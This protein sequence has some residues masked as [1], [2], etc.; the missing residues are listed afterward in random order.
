MIKQL[1]YRNPGKYTI[2][3][4]SGIKNSRS[5][6]MWIVRKTPDGKC[7]W[8]NE[9]AVKNKSAKYCD[10]ECGDSAM[11]YCYPQARHSKGFMLIKQEFKCATCVKDFSE[12]I[13][14][15]IDRMK[16]RSPTQIAD[17]WLV[18]CWI[19]SLMDADH[20]V[21]IVNGG[22]GF[23]VDNIHL[24]CKPCHKKKTNEDMK[25]KRE[26]EKINSR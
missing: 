24:I 17:N 6:N 26:R 16:K 23:G 21:A 20:K 1:N 4:L 19:S 11:V 3:L 18:G 10:R 13:R 2:E 8:C 7:A 22:S 9:F 25:C 12:H 15:M 14:V 5:I